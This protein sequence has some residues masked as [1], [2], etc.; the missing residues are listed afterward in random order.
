MRSPIRVDLRKSRTVPSTSAILSGTIVQ[1]HGLT[2]FQTTTLD[3]SF[4]LQDGP[5]QRGS[6]E[7]FPET[8]HFVTQPFY[9]GIINSPLRRRSETAIPVP[10][11]MITHPACFDS[12]WNRIAFISNLPDD[13]APEFV[14]IGSLF[15]VIRGIDRRLRS[16]LLMKIRQS[17]RVKDHHSGCES[18][19]VVTKSSVVVGSL[20]RKI[21]PCR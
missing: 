3:N 9:G 4:L 16:R 14:G 19:A 18:V 8:C 20:S 6:S 15:R 10:N 7:L 12:R 1:C 17:I 2:K 13:I 11:R 5:L 21:F